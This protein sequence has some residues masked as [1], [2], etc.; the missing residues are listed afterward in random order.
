MIKMAILIGLAFC[1]GIGAAYGLLRWPSERPRR[2]QII[3]E[4]EDGN[5]I[6]WESTDRY[7]ERLGDG[8]ECLTFDNMGVRTTICLPSE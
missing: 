6:G 2:A 8:A 3:E 7:F 1:C 5:Q 4:T